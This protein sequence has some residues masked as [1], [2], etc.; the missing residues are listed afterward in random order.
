M[1]A[2]RIAD[3]TAQHYAA[4]RDRRVP[5]PLAWCMTL[6]FHS[7]LTKS[8]LFDNRFSATVSRMLGPVEDAEQ[9]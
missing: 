1:F 6:R 8:V 7:G 4:L 9:R 2:E 3:E 5:P